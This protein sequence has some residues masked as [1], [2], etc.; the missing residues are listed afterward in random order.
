[1]FFAGSLVLWLGYEIWS[2]RHGR[3][4]ANLGSEFG[5]PV[6][7]SLVAGYLV[8]LLFAMN[9]IGFHSLSQEIGAPLRGVAWPIRVAAGMTFSLYLPHQPVATFLRTLDDYPPEN[10]VNRGIVIGGA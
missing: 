7:P 10:W 6:R 9:L 8:A 1:L 2:M 3:I 5:D 4:L